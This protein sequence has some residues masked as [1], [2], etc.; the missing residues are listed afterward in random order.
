M[1]EAEF[2]RW[3]HS[4]HGLAGE[5]TERFSNWTRSYRTQSE[6]LATIVA[7]EL[8]LSAV[9]FALSSHRANNKTSKQALG[10]GKVSLMEY[11]KYMVT[12]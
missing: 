6:E 4:G 2:E 7:Y 11:L 10:L 12:Q 5:Y 9:S 8:P 1:L 3:A